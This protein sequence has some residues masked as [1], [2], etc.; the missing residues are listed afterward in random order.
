[1]EQIVPLLTVSDV[2]RS[3]EFYRDKLGFEVETDLW[4]EPPLFATF[5]YGQC[6]IMVRE[7]F[8][9]NE[10]SPE[11]DT[12]RSP[13]VTLYLRINAIESIRIALIQ[14]G[15]PVGAI[16]IAGYGD[17]ELDIIDPDGYRLVYQESQ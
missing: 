17:R 8:D 4:R 14:R 10:R 3:L 2:Q 13:D 16:R 11:P 6:R 5:R 1:M 15:A 12:R 9:L 7:E